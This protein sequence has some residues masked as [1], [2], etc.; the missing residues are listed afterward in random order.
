METRKHF[1]H[2]QIAGFSY[3]EGPLVFNEL[4]VGAELTLV[5]EPN[6]KYDPTAVAVYYGNSK[7]GYLPADKN[8]IVHLLLEMGYDIFETRIQ[9]IDPATHPENQ[10]HIIIYIKRNESSLDMIEYCL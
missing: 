6:N 7:L 5:I 3:H 2:C 10:V 1:M 4:T 9:R 8:N